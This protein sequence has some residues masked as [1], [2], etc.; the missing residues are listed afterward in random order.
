[1]QGARALYQS[2]HRHIMLTWL[3]SVLVSTWNQ[4]PQTAVLW[5]VVLQAVDRNQHPV[6]LGPLVVQLL[7]HFRL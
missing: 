2:F 6:A 5:Q 1:M 7:G 3:P 4:R